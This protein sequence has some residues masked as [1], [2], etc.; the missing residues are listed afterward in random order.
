MTTETRPDPRDA[1]VEAAR[2]VCKSICR[3]TEKGYTNID[4]FAAELLQPIVTALSALPAPEPEEP[5]RLSVEVNENSVDLRAE[6]GDY[7]VFI[8]PNHGDPVVMATRF[9]ES[10]NLERVVRDLVQWWDERKIPDE[11]VG[12]IAPLAR[13]SLARIDAAKERSKR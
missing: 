8:R 9:A 4:S 10:A 1:V 3:L 2:T 12:K 13:E 6:N 7:V 5:E 11:L